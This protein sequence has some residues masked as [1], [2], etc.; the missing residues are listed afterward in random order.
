MPNFDMSASSD[1]GDNVP[2]RQWMGQPRVLRMERSFTAS[3]KWE[4]VRRR[5]AS[6]MITRLSKPDKAR[7]L[8]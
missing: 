3:R 7:L 6:S 2:L 5:W 1:L 4:L 8:S